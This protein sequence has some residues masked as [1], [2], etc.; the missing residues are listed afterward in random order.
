MRETDFEAIPVV[1]VATLRVD[2]LLL[3]GGFAFHFWP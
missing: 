3:A 2:P 1:G